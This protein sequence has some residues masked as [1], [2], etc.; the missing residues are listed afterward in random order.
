MRRRRRSVRKD[1]HVNV[2]SGRCVMVTGGELV[3]GE[4]GE[5]K[6]LKEKELI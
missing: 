2:E 4:V 6:E 1:A 5:R 3:C